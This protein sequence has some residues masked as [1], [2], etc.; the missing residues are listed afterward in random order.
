[1]KLEKFNLNLHNELKQIKQK[2]PY[3]ILD[4]AKKIFEAEKSI[5]ANILEELKT[6]EPKKETSIV[7]ITKLDATKIYS[8]HQIKA[9]CLTYRLKF[10]DSHRFK[11]DIPTETILKIKNEEKKLN[12]KFK[13]LKIIAPKKTL[14]L[15]DCDGDPLL[16]ASLNNG[17]YY[18]L[19]QWGNDLNK[20]RKYMAWPIKN[21]VNWLKF[22]LVLAVFLVAITPNHWI[23]TN[24]NGI[25]WTEQAFYGVYLF[26]TINIMALFFGLSFHENFSEYEWDKNSFN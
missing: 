11:G 4:E 20:L 10:V 9:L 16:F 26:M 2:Q 25:M 5:E 1:M 14:K 12:A 7:D 3:D 22:V 13:G 24:P 23:S 18:L 6:L 19:D 8:L 21:V 17:Q 15:G